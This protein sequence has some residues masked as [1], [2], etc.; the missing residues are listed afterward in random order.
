MATKDAR[1]ASS[2]NQRASEEKRRKRAN[3]E[4]KFGKKA[5]GRRMATKDAR[6]ASYG[7]KRTTAERPVNPGTANI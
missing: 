7:N 5:E 3:G 6:T 2:G 4:G 1:A